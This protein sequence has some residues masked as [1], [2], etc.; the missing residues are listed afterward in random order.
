MF[1]YQRLPTFLGLGLLAALFI[2]ALAFLAAG[3]FGPRT[4]D[5]DF[6]Y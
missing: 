5:A 4:A 6:A 1:R 2:A 3:S